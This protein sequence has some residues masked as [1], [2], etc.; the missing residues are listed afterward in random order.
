MPTLVNELTVEELDDRIQNAMR[1][2]LHE[3]DSLSDE[4]AIEIERRLANPVWLSHEEV[5][6][7]E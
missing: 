5:W 4:F 2:V 3:E 6:K 7:D 1:K